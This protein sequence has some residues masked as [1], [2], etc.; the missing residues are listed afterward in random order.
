MARKKILITSFHNFVTKNI[1]NTDVLT[2]LK[3]Q[4]DSGVILAVPNDKLDFFKQTYED[5]LVEVVGVDMDA[6][7]QNPR[8]KFFSRLFFSL[9]DS[10]YL[11]YKKQERLDKS[12]TLVGYLKYYREVCFTKC[13][14]WASWLFPFWRRLFIC[15]VRPASITRIFDDYRPGVVFSTDVFSEVDVL[16]AAEARRRRLILIGMVRSWD[17]C[18]SKGILRVLPDK[19]IVNNDT[20]KRAAVTIHKMDPRHIFVGG[21]PQFDH[22]LNEPRTPREQF[23]NSLGLDPLK[24]L[25]VF[26]PAGMILSDTDWQIGEILDQA[27]SRSKIVQSAQVL[28]RNHP[29]HP[30]DFSK[31]IA[32]KNFVIENP[33][34]TFNQNPKETEITRQDSIHLADTVY[35]ADLVIYVATTLGLDA[36]VYNKPQI[37]INFDGWEEK[38]YYHS[39]RRYHDEDHMAEMI[40]CGGVR[41]VSSVKEMIQSIND[42]LNDPT[43]DQTGRDK[44]VIQQLYKLDG[45]SGKRI[46]EFILESIN[47]K[48]P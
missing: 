25:I 20:L 28:I 42:Y 45:R 47:K 38:D 15:L 8:V 9:Q 21:L 37:I 41:V 14:A 39:V 12:R 32:T 5:S 43:L 44:M 1:L 35:Y 33:G 7:G 36:L 40:T 6:L 11:S 27:I 17:N 16:F 23:F 13:L 19:M 30:A 26:A 22:F 4:P 34:K 3:S 2:I 46:G 10:H 29:N 48:L 24:K 18:H 31:L